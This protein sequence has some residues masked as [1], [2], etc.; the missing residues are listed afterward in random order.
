MGKE[1]HKFDDLDTPIRDQGGQFKKIIIGEDCWVGN[2]AL[3]LANI[4]NK[5]VFGAGSVVVNDIPDF[6]IAAGNP[7]KIINSRKR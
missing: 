5:C 3:I 1:L 2:G 7:A 6:S 4:G